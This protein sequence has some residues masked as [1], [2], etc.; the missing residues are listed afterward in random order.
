VLSQH[1]AATHPPHEGEVSSGQL[2]S[3]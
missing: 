3:G 1:V 2:E